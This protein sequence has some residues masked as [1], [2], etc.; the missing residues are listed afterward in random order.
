M[1]SRV[2][3][4]SKLDLNWVRENLDFNSETGIFSWKLPG[5]GRTVGKPIGQEKRYKGNYLMM[6]INGELVYAHRLAW[7]YHYGVWPTNIVDHV[8]DDKTHNAIAN[9]REATS[10]QN[11]ARR[12]TT[13]LVGPSRG[14]AVHQNGFVARIEHAGKRHYLGYFTDA[15]EAKAAYEK[16]A[17]EIHGEFA[18]PQEAKTVRGD[19]LN[20]PKCEMCGRDGKW[21]AGDIRRDTTRLGKVRGALCL[22]CWDF[23][24]TCD[25]NKGLLQIMYRNAVRYVDSLDVFD[26]EIPSVRDASR[27][28]L[29][30]ASPGHIE[31][32]LN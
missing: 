22:N 23:V 6:R 19:Y 12:K 2:A 3:K 26:E 4:G 32:E 30:V 14:V 21:G 17:R 27:D 25:H 1:T 31:R 18:H 28:W 11:A 24:S 13:R 9:L 16:A 10:A 7:F 15:D 5:F 29:D 8:D 20:V